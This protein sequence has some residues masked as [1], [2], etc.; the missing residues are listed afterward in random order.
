MEAIVWLEVR[1]GVVEFSGVGLGPAAVVM[2]DIG[3]VNVPLSGLVV[4]VPLIVEI[5][6]VM[7]SGPDD[8]GMIVAVW[9]LVGAAVVPLSGAVGPAGMMGQQNYHL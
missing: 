5:G 9:L 8:I 3:A 2:L 6:E 4:V 1:A 7:F